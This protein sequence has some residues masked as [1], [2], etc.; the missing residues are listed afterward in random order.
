MNYTRMVRG[1]IYVLLLL[2]GTGVRANA[3]WNPLEGISAYQEP[4]VDISGLVPTPPGQQAF[5]AGKVIDGLSWTHDGEFL[6]VGT[7]SKMIASGGSWA[8]SW[9]RWNFQPNYVVNTQHY[10]LRV[11]RLDQSS[12]NMQLAGTIHVGANVKA[13][14]WSRNKRWIAVGHENVSGRMLSVFEFDASSNTLKFK[15]GIGG[16]RNHMAVAWHPQDES[17]LFAGGHFNGSNHGVCYRFAGS[18]L[19]EIPSSAVSANVTQNHNNYSPIAAAW[20]P[21]GQ[22]LAVGLGMY[23]TGHADVLLLQFD[24]Q[25]QTFTRLV[26][27]SY[28]ASHI[29][30]GVDFSPDG[31]F[32]VMCSDY[33]WQPAAMTIGVSRIDDINTLSLKP[34]AGTIHTRTL[35]SSVSWAPGSRHFVYVTPG[36][37]AIVEVNET[38]APNYAGR[39]IISGVPGGFRRA[40]WSPAGTHIAIA[41]ERDDNGLYFVGVDP[42]IYGLGGVFKARVA[43]RELAAYQQAAKSHVEA[44]ESTMEKLKTHVA[45]VASKNNVSVS[46]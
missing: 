36:E 30:Y 7:S 8:Y 6:A 2:L 21:S 10:E 24:S 28:D 5:T 37:V 44:L 11:Y 14:A 16:G 29:G 22:Y 46:A 27:R 13:V 32:A 20:H 9:G 3:E 17:L 34:T 15:H 12:G 19:Q 45:T 23:A 4:V 18:Y 1:G 40:S 39:R 31:R 42:N 26:D 38:G 41:T 43:Q 33:I 35:V 25:Q